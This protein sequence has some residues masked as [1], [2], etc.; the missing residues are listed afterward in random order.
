[1]V[2]DAM[3]DPSSPSEAVAW[4][5]TVARRYAPGSTIVAPRLKAF[6]AVKAF[7][8]LALA[9]TKTAPEKPKP[10]TRMAARASSPERARILTEQPS[11]LLGAPRGG[12]ARWPPGR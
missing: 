10:A 1:M 3:L 12:C 5:E 2:T 8:E 7:P 6:V 9:A 11:L 4:R